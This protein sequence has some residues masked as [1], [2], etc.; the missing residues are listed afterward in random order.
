ME[1]V[2]EPVIHTAQ[3]AASFARELQLLLRT[4]EVS[5][6]NMEKGEMRVEA[7]ISVSKNKGELG[8]KVEVKN[9]NSFKSV[10]RAIEFEVKRQTALIEAGE[11]VVQETRGW[12]ENKEATFSQRIKEEAA[13]YR[14]FPEPDLPK[15]K[16]SELPEFSREVLEKTLPELPSAKRARLSKSY[17]LTE[18][19]VEL[20]VTDARLCSFFETVVVLFENENDRAKLAKLASNYIL[21]N[22][23]AQRDT[24][25]KHVTE[26]VTPEAFSEIVLLAH[27]G[28][29]SSNGAVSLIQRVIQ[30]EGSDV[31]VRA[32]AEAE[33]LL[34]QNDEG[35]LGQIID[36]IL[37]ENAAVVAEYKAGKEQALQ[38]LV[39]QGMKESRG[40]ANPSKLK[41]LIQANIR[42]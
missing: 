27:G 33:G 41:E 25:E 14:Y 4:L 8:T 36:K 42:G 19:A 13:D 24:L 5:Y 34:Q 11:K 17:G 22:L 9:L 20:Y 40:S 18:E 30:N 7:N 39:G 38:F 2:T 35:A 21:N 6:A 3:Q 10:E 12:D 31:P 15:L 29:I 28:E 23:V 26:Y 37:S 32:L 1:L 16:L